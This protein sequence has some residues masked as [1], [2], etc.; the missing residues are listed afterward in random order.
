MAD[1][2][3]FIEDKTDNYKLF[4]EIN[5][6]E[7]EEDNIYSETDD[8]KEE[9]DKL[10]DVIEVGDR[11]IVLSVVDLSDTAKHLLDILSDLQDREV[12]LCSISEP[13]LDGSWYC[14]ALQELIDITRYYTEKK[15]QQGYQQAKEKGTVG[16]PAKT[17]E[18]E[19]AIKLYKTKAFTISE[20]EELTKI[21]K[22][23]L[24]RY[25]KEIDRDK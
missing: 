13:Y 15:R 20:I 3:Y 1:Y 5:K 12:I 25:L 8:S 17:A 22:T 21:S 9:L 16:R 11:L 19:Q 24:Y 10:L 18:I 4:R 2:A 23:T 6:L 7:I 14:S